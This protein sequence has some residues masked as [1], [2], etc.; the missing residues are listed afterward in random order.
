VIW[1]NPPAASPHLSRLWRMLPAV[2]ISVIVAETLIMTRLSASR[3]GEPLLIA[4]LIVD[5]LLLTV[6][7]I[8]LPIRRQGGLRD[9]ALTLAGAIRSTVIG[10]VAGAL[11]L[12]LLGLPMGGLATLAVAA[13]VVLLGAVLVAL[14]RAAKAARA[15]PRAGAGPMRGEGIVWDEASR[16]LRSALPAVV[17][18][19]ALLEVRLLSAALAALLRRPLPP[20]PQG[21][22]TTTRRSSS[23]QVVA[24][25]VGV[26][27][28]EL[29]AA[30]VLLAHFL[31]GLG[32]GP[33]AVIAAVHVWGVLW[34]LGDLRMCASTSHR[35]VGDTLVLELGLRFRAHVPLARILRVLPLRTDAERR[36]VQ[37]PKGM[38]PSANPRATPFDP[39][40]VHLCLEAPV[41]YTGLLGRERSFAHLDLYVDA[42]EAFIATLRERKG[43]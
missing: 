22:F 2:A 19:W 5:A 30:H 32:V 4:G 40:N 9:S 36:S 39:P 10:I 28:V 26:S 16:H 29:A 14:L 34:L 43:T 33:H 31:P 42:P 8:A 6:L 21:A 12:R 15:S 24:V 7:G 23:V 18:D 27:V 3:G 20:V 1:T 37:P 13:E 38:R 25:L 41:G 17:V 11:A 35:I